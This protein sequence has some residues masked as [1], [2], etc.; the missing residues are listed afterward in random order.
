MELVAT[1]AGTIGSTVFG[2][3][4]AATALT[5]GEVAALTAAA[6]PMAA[7]AV[8]PAATAAASGAWATLQGVM[9][10]ASA[11][12]SIGAGLA[13]L[14]EGSMQ[15]GMLEADATSEGLVAQAKALEIR[16]R[17]LKTM[18]EQRVAFAGSGV[19][20][21]SGTPAALAEATGTDR[22]QLLAIERENA[23][24][25]QARTRLAAAA[26][27][28][29]GAMS[30]VGGIGDAAGAVGRYGLDVARRG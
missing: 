1:L 17:A 19:D 29:R 30:L 26:A 18:A 20:I 22:D 16:N 7:A 3:G 8:V 21:A 24:I 6:S 10:G 9:T 25:R 5:A 15:A 27:R 4:A 2:T 28:T 12:A 14:A 23:I 13:G 11:I